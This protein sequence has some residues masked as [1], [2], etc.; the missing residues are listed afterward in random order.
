MTQPLVDQ[1]ERKRI[2]TDFDHNLVVEAA[3]GTGKTTALT[4]RLVALLE[5]GRTQLPR[6]VALTFTEKAAGEMKLRLRSAL[7][8]RRI[9]LATDSPE[10]ARLEAA[11]GALETAQVGTIHGFCGDLLRERPVQ[12]GIDPAFSVCAAEQEQQLLDQV[13]DRWFQG[14]LAQPPEGVRRVLRRHKARGS[15]VDDLRQAAAGLVQQRD[16]PGAFGRPAL[17]RCGRIDA[18]MA[19]LRAIA[20]LA[21]RGANPRDPLTRC[22]QEVQTFLSTQEVLADT[23]GT[24]D[25]DALEAGLCNLQRSRQWRGKGYGTF[26]GKELP[27]QDVLRVRDQVYGV[28][29]TTVH[30]LEADLAAALQQDLQVFVQAYEAEKQQ[31]GSLDFLDMLLCTRNLLRDQAEVRHELQDRYTHLFLDEFQDVD[32]LQA[33]IVAA[34]CCDSPSLRFGAP[35]GPQVP[36]GKLFVVG[37][38]KQAIYRFRRA[39]VHLYE[40]IKRAL[41]NDGAAV[42]QLTTS[43]RGRPGIQAA[44]NAGFAVH[45]QGTADGV[46]AHYQPLHAHRSEGTGPSVIALPIPATVGQRGYVAGAQISASAADAVGALVERLCNSGTFTVEGK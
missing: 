2:C 32:P 12:A 23:L 33:E 11:L 38:P 39:D 43:F 9:E 10:H 30:A 8:A 7:E 31:Q 13:F 17:D 36:A 18:A 24:C 27:R 46:Q 6:L 3:A 19:E 35:D 4:S 45:M 5:C 16:F 28:L 41:A 21:Q 40:R 37:D 42:L 34:L 29:T 26:Y 15:I 25:Y 14:C 1:A 44:I 20:P 22:L